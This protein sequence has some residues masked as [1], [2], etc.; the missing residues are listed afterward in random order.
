LINFSHDAAY[1][2]E[3]I[4]LNVSV[5]VFDYLKENVK[6]DMKAPEKTKADFIE[7]DNAY[8]V[9]DAAGA[10]ITHSIELLIM[11]LS[12]VTINEEG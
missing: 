6:M 2:K 4:T 9:R 7:D 10:D 5:R 3:L 1:V 12:N 8:V 11:L